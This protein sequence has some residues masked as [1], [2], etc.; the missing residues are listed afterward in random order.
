[1]VRPSWDVY[2]LELCE[3]VAKRATCDRGKTSCII[4]KDKRI[5]ATG[6]VGA[7]AGLPH[8]DEVG[9]LMRKAAD[10]TGMVTEHCVRTIHAEQNAIV[11]CAKYGISC[12]GATMYCRM[13]P[14]SVCA[15]LIISAGIKHVVSKKD[16]SRSKESKEMFAKAGVSFELIDKE[17]MKY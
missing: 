2:F 17:V 15:M 12:D 3:A 9:H 11:Q 7:P 14:C 8:C 16:Y 13:F 4:V 10:E 1:M 6:Y 5:L